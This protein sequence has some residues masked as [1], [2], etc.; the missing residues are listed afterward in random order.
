MN[1]ALTEP[2]GL[3]LIEAAACGLPVVATND[4]GPIDILGRCRNGLLVDVSSSEALRT[5]WRKPWL[6]MPLGSVASAGPRGCAAGLQLGGPCQP[7]FEG[8]AALCAAAQ[9][10]ST[11]N[12]KANSL[13]GRVSAPTRLRQARPA[14]Q[15]HA[16]APHGPRF[17]LTKQQ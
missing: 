10:E 16:H 2:F 12:L 9:L 11:A 6:L 7:L 15:S 8:G 4:G 3:T 5:T 17:W 13:R 1:P 14:G